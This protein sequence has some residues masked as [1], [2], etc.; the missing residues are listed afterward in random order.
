MNQV[1]VQE[2][3][4]PLEESKGD[5]EASNTAT[6]KT[7]DVSKIENVSSTIWKDIDVIGTESKVSQNGDTYTSYIVEVMISD[8]TSW[9]V[10]NF[11]I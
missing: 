7:Y 4:T 8:G 11:K 1:L 9:K 3:M 10:M 5:I 6:E 2:I